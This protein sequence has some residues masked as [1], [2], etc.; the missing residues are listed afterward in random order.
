M[1]INS[2]LVSIIIPYFNGGETI[3]ETIDS[4]FNQTYS[5]FEIWIINDGSTNKNSTEKLKEFT[6]NSKINIIHQQ[7]SGPSISRNNAI[8]KSNGKYIVFLDSDDIIE[9]KT[10]EISINVLENNPPIS[11]VYGNNRHFGTKNFIRTQ[12]PLDIAELLVYNTIAICCTIRKSVFEDGFYFDEYLSKKGLEDYEFW[13][14]LASNNFKFHYL[15]ELFFNI[16]ISDTSRTYQVAN[17][18]ITEIK[19][20]IFKKH[21][22]FINSQ[23]EK[24][25]YKSKMQNESIN[26]KIGNL[27][28]YPYRQIKNMLLNIRNLR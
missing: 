24:L 21:A 10:I 2:P 14:N 4:I 15:N 7:N 11:I 18:N 5:N 9:K 27:I 16:R 19:N 26:N 8:K 13:I 28:L 25:F 17:T 20:Y 6:T 23:Y 1:T 22:N 3:N 12:K